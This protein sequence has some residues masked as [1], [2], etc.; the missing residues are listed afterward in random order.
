MSQYSTGQVAIA[1]NIPAI[2]VIISYGNTKG[3]K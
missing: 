3:K 1:Q 2:I